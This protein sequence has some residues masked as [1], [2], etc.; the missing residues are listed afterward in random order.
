M[1]RFATSL[2]RG[3]L[4]HPRVAGA[5]VLVVTGL[6]LVLLPGF[7][8]D[9]DV[10]RM[11]PQQS[12]LVQLQRALEPGSDHGRQM[13]VI[14]RGE[15]LETRVPRVAE[16]LRG[17]PL[18][19]SVAVTREEF[20][21]PTWRAA[22]EA[23]LWYLPEATLAAL[24]ER[25]TSGLAPVLEAGHER[26]AAD[27][28]AGRATFVADPL[29]LRFLLQEGTPA[30][31]PALRAGS[32]YVLL[33]DRPIAL[34]RVEGT[35]PPYDVDYS[36]R[37]LADLETRVGDAAPEWFGGYA[38]A[39]AEASRSRADLRGSALGSMLWIT[40][41]LVVSMRRI[42]LPGALVATVA[43][44]VLWALPLGGALL[45]PLSP[46]AISAAAV[47]MGLGIDFG[48]HYAA[49]YATARARVPHAEAVAGAHRDTMR[50]L[51]GGMATTLAAFGAL[52]AGELAGL[53]GFALL[54]AIGL[55]AAFVATLLVLPFLLRPLRGDVRA[56]RSHVVDAAAALA[57]GRAGPACMAA[58]LIFAVAGAI[59]VAARGVE[60]ST[61]PDRLRPAAETAQRSAIEAEL[62]ISPLGVIALVPADV[63]EAELA[64]GIDALQRR[65]VVQFA[66]G[67]PGPRQHATRRA[68]VAALR[69]EI[70]GWRPRADRVLAELR[71]NP[72]PFAE[73]LDELATALAADPVPSQP[74]WVTHGDTRWRQL[75]L[76][77]PHSFHDLAAWEEFRGAVRHELGAGTE[78]LAPIA[79]MAELRDVLRADL[80]QAL[81]L[82]GAAS[83]IVLMFLLRSVTGALLAMLPAVCGLLVTLGALAATGVPLTPVNFI[84]LP[85]LLGIGIDDGVH[86]VARARAG[87]GL[88]GP[89]GVAIWRTSVTTMLA[90]GTLCFAASPG[91]AELGLLVLLGVGTCLLT[92][93]L[94]LPILL[95]LR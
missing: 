17:S 36:Q 81:W 72:E 50:P 30:G 14:L 3:T 5:L 93:L 75:R 49:H 79:A 56:P 77:V 29:E 18:L 86:L 92:T 8:V 28:L 11:L 51:L 67:G 23:P 57:R 42:W 35:Q 33:A 1:E 10:S 76:F 47:L 25:L 19:A 85:L 34:L 95:R 13:F 41:F 43:L 24:A 71:L 46:I 61:D 12:R 83:L 84:A 64:E 55:V 94:T 9:P 63:A 45:G 90:F 31:M 73:A 32:P 66:Q 6:A 20:F 87:E 21:G 7:R 2:A 65:A 68:R 88:S 78:L 38:I 82:A 58:V 74:V 27:P 26:L 69:E 62:G 40:L 39:R 53:R 59:A 22:R 91:L 15:D 52:A 16:A 54:L 48:L 89:T 70:A 37:L 80:R 60:L 4:R 44:A